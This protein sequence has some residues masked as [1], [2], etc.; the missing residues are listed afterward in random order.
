MC[1][2]EVINISVIMFIFKVHIVKYDVDAFYIR[3]STL[4]LECLSWRSNVTAWLCR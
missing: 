3:Y 2:E 1:M 4:G